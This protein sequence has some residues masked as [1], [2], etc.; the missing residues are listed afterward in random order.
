MTLSVDVKEKPWQ[1]NMLQKRYF[2]LA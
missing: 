2:F 1:E